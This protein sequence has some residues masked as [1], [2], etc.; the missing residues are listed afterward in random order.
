MN[1]ISFG[2][3]YRQKSYKKEQ[4]FIFESKSMRNV[5]KVTE[6]VKINYTNGAKDCNKIKFLQN[7]SK[8]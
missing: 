6:E 5:T 1:N 4:L 8:W 7:Y 3:L 2:I